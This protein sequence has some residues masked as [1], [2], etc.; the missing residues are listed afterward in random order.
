MIVIGGDLSSKKLAVVTKWSTGFSMV[1]WKIRAKAPYGAAEA[2]NGMR[3]ILTALG[4][5]MY[6]P[7]L[8]AIERPV[9]GRGV[10]ATLVQSYVSGA[11]Q[12]V[13]VE[14]GWEVILVSPSSWKAT[15]V[16]HGHA[17]KGA[18]ASWLEHEQPALARAARSQDLVD[19]ACLALYAEEVARSRPLV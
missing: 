2:A 15:V 1:E 19:A 14:H 6:S 9:V 8:A 16:G 10:H 3:R 12:A 7:G 5:A 4:D 13:L 18:V 17:N 11:V